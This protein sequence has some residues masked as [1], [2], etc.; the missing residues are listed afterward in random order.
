MP[1]HLF[2]FSQ[3]TSL[4]SDWE[5]ESDLVTRQS[6]LV[7][8]HNG[9]MLKRIFVLAGFRPLD[10]MNFCVIVSNN[11]G[12]FVLFCSRVVDFL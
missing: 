6:L 12:C 8:E 11:S 5:D 2:S 9:S 4:S 3:C 7:P 1:N 10:F